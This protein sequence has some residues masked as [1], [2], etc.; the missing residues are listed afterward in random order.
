MDASELINSLSTQLEELKTLHSRLEP[1]QIIEIDTEGSVYHQIFAYRRAKVVIGAKDS[2]MANV[3]WMSKHSSI[4]DITEVPILQ[5][6]T[7][8]LGA[9][10]QLDYYALPS[11]ANEGQDKVSMEI[12]SVK[13]ALATVLTKKVN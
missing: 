2:L 4:I 9:L 1:L 11:K 5:S 6:T 8:I 13:K 3:A 7:S 12:E 10:L